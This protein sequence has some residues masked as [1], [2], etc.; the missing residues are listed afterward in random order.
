MLHSYTDLKLDGVGV[1]NG[2]ISRV[3]DVIRELLGLG[4]V[5]AGER[6]AALELDLCSYDAFVRGACL[7][8]VPR[9]WVV[10]EDCEV[11]V[12]EYVGCSVLIQ[13]LLQEA[14]TAGVWQGG[15][16]TER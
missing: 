15:A 12:V 16:L 1:D 11:H 5:R 6:L 10:V 3:L 2:E 8:L 7:L 9:G 4:L 13:L 14:I